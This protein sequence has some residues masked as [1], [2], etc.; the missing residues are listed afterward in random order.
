MI[1]LRT[2]GETI[3]TFILQNLNEHPN[4]IARVVATQFGISRQA[5]NQHLKALVARGAV[6]HTGNTRARIYA[7]PSLQNWEKSFPLSEDLEEDRVWRDDIAPILTDL[8]KNA[9]GIWNY[10]FTEMLNN[11]KDH[12]AGTSLRIQLQRNAESARITLHD[13]GV[14]IFRKIQ[15]ALGLSDE[16]HAVLEL[17]KG[18]L[19]TD[20]DRHTGEGIFFTSRMF[21]EFMIDSGGVHFS[22]QSEKKE[23]WIVEPE[24]P[25]PGTAVSMKLSN[26]T[27]KTA[28]QVFD[29]F[30]SGDDYGFTKT[31]VPVKLARYGTENLV[32]RSQAKRLLTRV[33]KFKTVI[34]DFEGIDAIGQSFADEIFR[35]FAKQNTGIEL[36]R[37]N[38]MPDVENMIARAVG[39]R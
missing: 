5:A 15:A 28:K 2:G 38:A 21:D 24:E 9:V 31:I 18:K 34:L 35:V 20:P 4:D 23:D 39:N 11:A 19:T 1:K 13:N 25:L 29:Q 27:T 10:G 22:H 17:A 30:T 37:S 14:G 36:L 3:Q 7:M 33:E 6:T 8:P 26:H 12:A 16:R 32:S